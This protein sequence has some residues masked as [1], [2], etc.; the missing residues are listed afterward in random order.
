MLIMDNIKA[1]LG[2]ALPWLTMG[3]VIAFFVSR[4]VSREKKGEEF[5]DNYGGEGMCIGMSFGVCLGT[6]FHN[7]GL[8]CS[9]GML[10]GLAIGT[11]IRKKPGDSPK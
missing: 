6:L 5:E 7:V 4:S 10:V 11:S 9:L 8:G 3:V 2:A 1:F